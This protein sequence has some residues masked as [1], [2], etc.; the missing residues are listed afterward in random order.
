MLSHLHRNIPLSDWIVY[1]GLGY[2]S[3]P[4][5]PFH[6]ANRNIRKQPLTIVSRSWTARLQDR[7]IDEGS[8]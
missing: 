5:P 3:V 8:I 7:T 2:C 1:H 6:L 4:A